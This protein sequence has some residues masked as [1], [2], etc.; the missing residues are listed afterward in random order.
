M[1]QQRDLLTHRWRKVAQRIPKEHELQIALMQHVRFRGRPGLICFHVPNGELR[2][3]RTAAKL[4]A[5]GTLPG[6]SDLV[7]V[8]NDGR[9]RNLYLELKVGSN[10][11]TDAQRMF[12]ECVVNAGGYHQ[13]AST[14]DDALAILSLYRILVR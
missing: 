12:A 7:F 5:M 14:I 2:D 10:K 11:M 13:C 3:K 8:W 9:L 1:E 6:V 4:K